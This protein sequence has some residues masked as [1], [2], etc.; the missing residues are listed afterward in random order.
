MS[1]HYNAPTREA[2]ITN[3]MS[4]AGLAV[5]H[6]YVLAIL[7]T[8]RTDLNEVQED[9]AHL[10]NNTSTENFIS[11]LE[12]LHELHEKMALA[13]KRMELI[14]NHDH[15]AA[16]ERHDRYKQQSTKDMNEQAQEI[17]QRID[18]AKRL[19]V[20][21]LAELKQMGQLITV[22]SV[23][24]YWGVVWPT[25][26]WLVGYYCGVDDDIWLT[27]PAEDHHESFRTVCGW[28]GR[29]EWTCEVGN[30]TDRVYIEHEGKRK[31]IG[32]Y[33]VLGDDLRQTVMNGMLKLG[34]REV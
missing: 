12:E 7:A 4:A 9:L 22:T 10:V 13:I 25:N 18:T 1:F 20:K 27:G 2:Q 3:K 21:E 24:K 6:K 29:F 33:T 19:S 17:Q 5:S 30:T 15:M 31:C 26:D 8:Q 32:Y 11:I 23:G 14:A 28:G 16:A 34:A